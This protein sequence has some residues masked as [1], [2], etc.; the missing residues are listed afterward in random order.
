[1][2]SI[3]RDDADVGARWNESAAWFLAPPLKLVDRLGHA[4]RNTELALLLLFWELCEE[5]DGS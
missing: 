1:M 2:A 5:L 3:D 4:K